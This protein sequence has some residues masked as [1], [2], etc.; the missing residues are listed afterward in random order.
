MDTTDDYYNNEQ[1]NSIII[2]LENRGHI[3]DISYSEFQKII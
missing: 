1:V 3:D 2:K